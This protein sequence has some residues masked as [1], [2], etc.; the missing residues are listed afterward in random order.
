MFPTHISVPGQ[1][2]RCQRRGVAPS[3]EHRARQVEKVGSTPKHPCQLAR[4]PSIRRGGILT[5]ANSLDANLLVCQ[6]RL[7]KRII[8]PQRHGG[9]WR[10]RQRGRWAEAQRAQQTKS[11][12]RSRT[13]LQSYAG[14]PPRPTLQPPRSSPGRR[15]LPSWQTMTGSGPAKGT[16]CS[17]TMSSAEANTT[18]GEH[19]LMPECGAY[20]FHRRH[21]GSIAIRRGRFDREKLENEFGFVINKQQT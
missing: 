14:D 17:S 19:S 13:P 12:A 16:S 8:L 5:D 20:L 11:C 10:S 15:S 4:M 2:R 3:P 1:P 6:L 7:L 18:T 21:S 9:Q